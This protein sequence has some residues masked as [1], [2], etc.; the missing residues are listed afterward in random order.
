MA[1]FY[2]SIRANKGE[3]TRVGTPKSDIEGHIRGW[4]LG[5]RVRGYVDK[6]GNDRFDINPSTGSSGH[7][8]SKCLGSYTKKD[9]V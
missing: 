7:G 4:N 9:L 2:A 6:D 3:V 8:P 1:H 5:V